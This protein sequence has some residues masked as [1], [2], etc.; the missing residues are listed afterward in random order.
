MTSSRPFVVAV[1]PVSDVRIR[2]RIATHTQTWGVA[3]ATP[4]VAWKDP[5]EEKKSGIQLSIFSYHR[6]P[7]A[8]R[9]VAM[10]MFREGIRMSERRDH[11]RLFSYRDRFL[12]L[13]SYRDGAAEPPHQRSSETQCVA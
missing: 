13:F 10:R 1:L 3:A 8:R 9:A 7:S 2:R 6:R 4:H 12:D 11:A 5:E